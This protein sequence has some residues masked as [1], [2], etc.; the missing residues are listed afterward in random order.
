MFYGVLNMQGI[1]YMIKV[2]V[3]SG[4]INEFKLF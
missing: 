1:K 3:K 2:E 4:E